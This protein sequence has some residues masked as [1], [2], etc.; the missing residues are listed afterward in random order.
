MLAIDGS[1]P[2]YDIVNRI[3]ENVGHATQTG[4]EVVAEQQIADLWRVS[5]SANWFVH[6]IDA[7]E[8]VLLFP[9]ARPFSLPASED[10][11]RDFTINNRVRLPSGGEV[12]LSYIYYAG[13]N[14]P[15]GWE[16]ARSSLD[17]AARWP[18]WND[19]AEVAFTFTDILDDFA[20]QREI[21]GDGFTALYENLLETQVATVAL[22]YRF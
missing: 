16:R 2:N 6:D 7:L 17:L 14:V 21:D 4:V 19:R 11:T 18:I 8:T 3:F 1:N 12:Q 9:T 20:V 5:G 13:R 10:D 15:Q 22:R